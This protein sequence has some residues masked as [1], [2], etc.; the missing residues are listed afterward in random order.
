MAKKY[1]IKELVTMLDTGQLGLSPKHFQFLYRPYEANSPS[2]KALLEGSG[3]REIK[4]GDGVLQAYPTLEN[5]N[6][7][8]ESGLLFVP[9]D[10]VVNWYFSQLLIETSFS[11]S[12]DWQ[13]QSTLF[14][15]QQEGARFLYYHNR[16]MLSLSPGL[17]K[18]LTSAY[19]AGLRGFDNVLVVCPASLLYYWK[20]EL[21]K[22]AD[23]LP[24][25][26]VTF[27]WHKKPWLYGM[28]TDPHKQYWAITNPET[29]ARNLD[30]FIGEFSEPFNC[31]IVDESIMYKHRDSQRSQAIKDLAQGIETTW[32]LTGAPATRYLDDMWNQFHIL[33][34]KGYSSYWRF[35]RKYCIIEDNDW[36]SK[37]VANRPN[38]EDEIKKN[39]SDIYFSRTQ[40]DVANIPDW[41]MEDI[42][43]PMLP[44]QDKAYET[45]RKELYIELDSIDPG[46]KI[47]VNNH[48]SLMIRSVQVASNPLL[49]GSINSAAKWDALPELMEIYPGPYIIWVNFI[50]TGELLRDNLA[51]QKVK[52]AF[53]ADGTLR[54]ALANGATKMEDRNLMVNA[55]Q[56]GELDVLIL[57]NQ[58]GKFGFTLTEARTA[59]FVERM[60]D[61]SYFQCLHRNRRI[62]TTVSPVIV[63]MRSVT[64]SGRRTI[65]HLIHSTLDYRVGMIKSVTAGDLRE[66]FAE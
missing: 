48:L 42:D 18:T 38:A 7:L 62:G 59:F 14:D 29:V 49:V 32:F 16:A 27:V 23:K 57:N 6:A 25:N 12:I 5:Y 26:P 41:I 45:L 10:R 53:T 44:A 19:A 51:Q 65:D 54:V 46:Q 61:D 17:G 31:L 40:D 15:Y 4:D 36:G 52:W 43:I 3:W 30:I 50:K 9:T 33:K 37:V 13:G 66:V 63:N 55:F 34:P 35:A 39:F 1:P 8:K 22:W 21:E 2:V 56:N 24:R 47:T 64:Q 60:Y 28:S 58:V 20:G 11:E